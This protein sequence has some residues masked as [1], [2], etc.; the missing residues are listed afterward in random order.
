VTARD[1][2]NRVLWRLGVGLRIEP[3]APRVPD[4]V[5]ARL[6]RELAL[7]R[8]QSEEFTVIE[9]LQD[10]SQPHPRRYI[11]LECEF[12]S[13]QLLRLRPAII[14]DVGSYR[15]WLIGLMAHFRVI[16]VDVRARESRLSNETVVTED[17]SRLGLPPESVDVVTTLCSLEHFGLGRYGDPFD[18][19]ADRKAVAALIRTIRP[20]GHFLFTA[21]ITA[22]VPCLAFNAHRIYTLPMLRRLMAGLQCEEERFV[23][24]S[25]A[26]YCGTDE[27]TTTL[28]T[29]DIYCGCFQKPD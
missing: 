1:F 11:D 17:A 22:G 7:A 21:P 29:F 5:R 12:A 25:P 20:G 3:G 4:E 13:E 23:K 16:T 6:A 19:E 18:L 28:G 9:Q 14:L 27:L 15:Q 10:D 24:A 26:R 2:V 8:A